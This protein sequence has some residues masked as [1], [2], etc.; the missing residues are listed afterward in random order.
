M[1]TQVFRGKTLIDARQQAVHVLGKGA[2]ILT[3]REVKRAGIGGLFGAMDF[4][5][6][7]AVAPPPSDT[8][9]RFTQ[10]PFA[11]SAYADT[12]TPTKAQAFMDP[13]SLGA[14]RADI[15]A[16][17]MALAKTTASPADLA[18]ELVAIRE[19]LDQIAPSGRADSVARFLA[20]RGIEG[21]AAATLGR[22]MRAIPEGSGTIEDRLRSALGKLI[23]IGPWPLATKAR[24][25]I[26]AVGPTGVGKTT[27]IAKLATLAKLSDK[28]VTLVTC[29]TYRVGGIE[30]IKRYASL[31][32]VRHEV[33]RD[34]R[35]LA[36]IIASSQSDVIFVDT[37]G[38]PPR[39]D[40]AEGVL[41]PERFGAMEG[42]AAR[43]RYVLLC[44]PAATRWVDAVRATRSFGS[45][46]P[47]A[48]AVTKTDE[49]DAP[50][51]LI[52]AAMASKLPLSV[53]CTGQRVPE[54]IETPTPDAVI[55]RI[56]DGSRKVRESK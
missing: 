55:D 22:A 43:S 49:T 51:G 1:T 40:S 23:Q 25:L 41:A 38:R 35:G 12:S 21:A 48:I 16:M 54:D 53:I 30:Q 15:R 3:T 33:A 46:H 6:A 4:E 5:V 42:A 17:K 37:S 52:H 26:A 34:A 18:S 7:A 20:R 10:G 56:V 13:G 31:L 24:T 27:T 36:A 29:D 9:A 39:E 2:V 32:D 14:L 44:L 11:P 50:S 45:A 8:K 19:I 28:S 47:V